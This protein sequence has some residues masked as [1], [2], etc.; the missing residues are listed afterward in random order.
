MYKTEPQKFLIFFIKK[1]GN[2]VK[3]LVHVHLYAQYKDKS[4][5]VM[6]V[7]LILFFIVCF[8]RF[9]FIAAFTCYLY[10]YNRDRKTPERSMSLLLTQLSWK[11]R[12]MIV[13]YTP[14]SLELEWEEGYGCEMID[15]VTLNDL[16][17][18]QT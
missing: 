16:T 5:L 13:T 12:L 7:D 11:E 18:Y 4:V 14:I 17:T 15:R 6:F 9:V 3:K 8:C 10:N 1:I 2:V